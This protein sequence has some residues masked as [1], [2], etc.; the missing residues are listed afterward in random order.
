MK[1]FIAVA[2][3][4]IFAFFLSGLFKGAQALDVNAVFA[5]IKAELI[6]KGMSA[7]DI[8]AVEPPVKNMLSL[9][10]TQ[11]DVKSIL[12]DLMA[13]GF[14]G[15]DLSSLVGMVSDLAKSGEPVKNSGAVV[16]QAIQGASVLGLKGKDLISKVQNM[17]NQR[18]AQLSQIKGNVSATGQQL[19]NKE[20]I[21]KG[22]TSIFGQ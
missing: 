19:Q 17:V 15:N 7:G 1:R 21:K 6:Q 16:S 9:G 4:V 22:I 18:K 12:L 11:S 3:L 2:M 8:K 20:N 5:Q 14:K 10:G 13:K